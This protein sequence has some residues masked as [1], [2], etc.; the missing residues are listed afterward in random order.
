M[1]HSMFAALRCLPPARLDPQRSPG[2]AL[3]LSLAGPAIPAVCRRF[4]GAGRHDSRMW[5][6][7]ASLAT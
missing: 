3:P 1:N 5:E 7:D 2:R 6:V 4:I